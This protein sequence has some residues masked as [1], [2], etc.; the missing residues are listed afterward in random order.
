[1][2]NVKLTITKH[3]FSSG[4]QILYKINLF[5]TLIMCW[6]SMFFFVCIDYCFARS[7]LFCVC[8]KSQ[9]ILYLPTPIRDS[10]I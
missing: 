9:L 2:A 10:C 6:P 7:A 8:I 4:A 1:M 3:P 5:S